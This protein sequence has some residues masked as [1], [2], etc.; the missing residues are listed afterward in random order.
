MV[1]ANWVL[2]S[3]I[4]DDGH[5]YLFQVNYFKI[6]ENIVYTNWNQIVPMKK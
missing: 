1:I 5:F 2:G 3:F 6:F 4:T